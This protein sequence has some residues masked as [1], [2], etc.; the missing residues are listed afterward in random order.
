ME[1]SIK[2]FLFSLF[3]LFSITLKG[4]TSFSDKDKWEQKILNDVSLREVKASLSQQFTACYTKKQIPGELISI[5]EKWSSEKITFANPNEDYN[6]TDNA[7]GNLPNRQLIAI[8]KSNRSVF[9]VYNHG[10]IGFHQDIIWCKWKEAKVIDLW[11]AHYK[12]E[13]VDLNNIS[14]FLT[15]FSRIHFLRNGKRIKENVVCF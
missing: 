7:D 6:A 8:Y 15:E 5:L 13:T 10:G 3:I 4:Q 11:I 14:Q 9:V 2:F 1:R 12:G